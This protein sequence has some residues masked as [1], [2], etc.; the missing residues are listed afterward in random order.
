MSI[1][2]HLNKKIKG[3]YNNEKIHDYILNHLKKTEILGILYCLDIISIV[4][5]KYEKAVPL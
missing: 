1:I 2:K 5:L 3:I 4:I